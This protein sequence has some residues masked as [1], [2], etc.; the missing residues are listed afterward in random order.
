MGSV[1]T[2]RIARSLARWPALFGALLASFAWLASG[3][4]AQVQVVAHRGLLHHAP[5]NTLANYR[6]C[7]QL[8][9]GFE[10]DVRRSQD[11]HLVCV[12]D[13]TVD[14]TTDGS[15]RVDALSL[16]QLKAL[17]AGSW[18]GPLFEGERIPTF[19]EVLALLPSAPG[20]PALI[21][22]DLK[23]AGIAVDVVRAA[24]R[25][26]VLSQLL[27][28]GSAIRDPQVRGRLREADKAAHVACLA[29]SADGLAAAL[30]DVASDW[31][32][33]RYLP[34][35]AELEE[36]HQRGKRAFLAGPV[37]AGR[38]P[39]NWRRAIYAGIDGILTDYP[40]ELAALIRIGAAGEEQ[41]D[42]QG[43]TGDILE[44]GDPQ[45]V[46][47]DSVRLKTAVGLVEQAIA[48]GEMHGAVLLVARRGRIILHQALGWRSPQR[49][50][51]M[52]KD[53]L[54]RMAS[55]SK[56]ITAAGILAL[57][58]DGMLQLDDPVHMYLPAF[59]AEK[60]KR[61]TIR[62]LLTHTSGLRI[63]PLFLKPLLEKSPQLPDAP[64]LL[65]E[66]SRFAQI[67]ATVQPGA[68]YKY[69][70]AG[71]N[72][73][74]GVIE[75]LTGSYQQHLRRCLYEPLGMAASSNH[76]SMAEHGKMSTVSV[77]QADGSW[78]PG[79]QPGDAPDF[80]F[81]RGSGGMISS[82]RDYAIFCQMLLNRG[83]YRGRRILPAALVQQAVNPQ[84]SYIPAAEG[85]GLG[86]VVSKAGGTYAHSG[87]DGTWVWV[88]PER[89]M[90][91]LVLTQT[92]GST[93]P[94][95]AFRAMV[96][97][98][99]LDRKR[100]QDGPGVP[101][102]AHAPGFYKDIFMSSGANLTS[103][104]RLFAA[105]SL[106]LSYEY[107]AG[108][109]AI[110]QNKM[111]VGTPEDTNGVLLYPDGQPRFRMLYV[112]GGGAT[113]HGKSL[114][115][116]GR[117]LLR[118]FHA[119]GGSYCG[120]CA[121]S[122]LSGRNVD[123]RAEPR[124]GYLHIFPYNT[125]N[126]GLKKARLTHVIPEDSPLLQFRKFGA[127]RQI[128]AVYHNN[129]NWLSTSTGEHLKETEILATYHHPDHKIDGGAAIWAYRK[130]TSQGRVVNIGSHPEGVRAGEQLALTQAC[131]LY[132][133][134]GTGTPPV[135][136]TLVSGSP[137]RMDRY[138]ADGE[139]E[140]TR[141]GDRQYHHF[142][143][144]VAADTPRVTIDIQGDADVDL[145]LY[146]QR[147]SVAL[148]G[149]AVHQDVTPG[150]AKRLEVTLSPGTWYV[151]VHC[152]TTVDS[153]NDPQSGFYRYY[154]R[155]DLLNGVAYTIGMLQTT[156]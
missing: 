85:Y 119:S 18:F 79:W 19:D 59:A 49:T 89:E 74:A 15:G 2:T 152:A 136:G 125:L 7:L 145:H 5:E 90:I 114:T 129:G 137:R 52:Q 77:R 128:E 112:N 58:A 44:P 123:K 118:Q 84:V 33:F 14:R 43:A 96:Q 53:A 120:S 63:E 35:P 11:G 142:R 102:V 25:A 97:D 93:N 24:R 113:S 139:P 107:Y 16:A 56:A 115:L 50:E 71:Y 111:L 76:E 105:E 78:Q 92:K 141:I 131:F 87:S 150:A 117:E 39:L 62:Q 104:K 127:D 81:P 82:A 37:V 146:L 38:E 149:Q 55:N 3:L 134:E 57:V 151:G 51:P 40:M 23:A 94:R 126:T 98:A 26:G 68:S 122:F 73:L 143:F 156:R 28:I 147:D 4:A 1:G 140:M 72:I 138:T 70:N 133:L 110:Q 21:S 54:F 101:Q 45:D 135:K 144:E 83:I 64:N 69:N 132:A 86:W 155:R 106:A 75:T 95:H 88:D 66:I 116:K 108:K 9:I 91:G 154:A 27:F 130:G 22:V 41:A 109:D 46:Q 67:G 6:A 80:P 65:L 32:Y 48:D 31:V 20:S 99:C 36:V 13:A 100:D 30:D 10:V 47:V 42:P 34:R 60:S 12:H 121:G 103:R 29:N 148:A 17:D 124:L 61:I 153:I 8:R